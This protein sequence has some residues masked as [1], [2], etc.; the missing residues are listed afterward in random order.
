L[1][2]LCIFLSGLFAFY[3]EEYFVIITTSFVGSFCLI[4]GI[5][6]YSG[7]FDVNTLIDELSEGL[8]TYKSM[9][10]I[11]YAYF[12]GMIIFCALSL[13]FQCRMAK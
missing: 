1:I 6:Y 4:R 9:D 2:I 7:G 13:V 10:K 3:I 11:Y 8:I 12:S 5:S